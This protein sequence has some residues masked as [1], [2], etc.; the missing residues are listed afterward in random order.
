MMDEH[1]PGP[2]SPK[3][4]SLYGRANGTYYTK[5]KRYLEA[6]GSTFLTLHALFMTSVL[7][8]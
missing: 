5:E 4:M 8:R 3:S 6:E 7:F 1:T 2:Y